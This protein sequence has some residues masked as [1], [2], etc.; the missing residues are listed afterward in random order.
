MPSADARRIVVE[1]EP[2]EDARALV[3]AG[4]RSFNRQHAVPPDFQPLTLTAR[5]ATGEILGGAVAETGWQWLHVD[6]LWVAE[7]YRGQGIG[8]ELLHAAERTARE[9]GCVHSYLDTF[10]FQALPFYE[11]VGYAVF[12]IQNDYPP[13]H[14]RYYLRK[15]LVESDAQAT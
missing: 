13:G 12:G 3:R 8:R 11:R 14:D 10:D 7:P 9:R 15:M 2:A 4:L 6:L 5:T 1:L